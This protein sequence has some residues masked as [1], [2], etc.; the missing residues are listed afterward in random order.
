MD[1]KYDYINIFPLYASSQNYSNMQQEVLFKRTLQEPQYFRNEEFSCQDA[2]YKRLDAIWV[3][4]NE[5]L[6]TEISMV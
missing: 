6:V 2:T 3:C 1:H 4:M 5:I